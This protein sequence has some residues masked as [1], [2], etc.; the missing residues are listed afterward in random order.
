M[1]SLAAPR[2]AVIV[3]WRSAAREGGMN[4][5]PIRRLLAVCLV[6]GATAALALAVLGAGALAADPPG[7]RRANKALA[8]CEREADS[9]E[10]RRAL[11]ARGLTLAEEA[12]AADDGDAKAHFAVVCNLGKEMELRGVSAANLIS[13]RRLRREIDRTLALAPDYADALLAKGALLSGLPRL[14][15]GDREEGERF[16]RAALAVDPDYLGA[17]LALAKALAERGDREM[18][19]TEAER[20]LALAK[21]RADARAAEDARALVARLEN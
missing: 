19:R 15:G 10:E 18:A 21:V 14:L 13:L 17:H 16:M 12:V 3:Y 9:V 8:L 20:A 4:G 7:S 5:R 2:L 6:V 11:L 1:D